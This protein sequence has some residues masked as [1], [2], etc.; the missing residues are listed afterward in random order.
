MGFDWKQASESTQA[1]LMP[2]GYHKAKVVKVV[3]GKKDGTLFVSRDNDPQVMAVFANEQGEEAAVM[4]TLSTK[5]SWL[6]AKFLSCAGADLE[7]MSKE[8][9]T[10]DRFAD[11]SFAQAQLMNQIGRAHV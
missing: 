7:R 9:V 11:Q 2:E 4:F 3:M 5:A 6:L 8:G 10:P 1:A